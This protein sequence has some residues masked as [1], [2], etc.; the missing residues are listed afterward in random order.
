M[1]LEVWKCCCL[2]PEVGDHY[3]LQQLVASV[4]VT[5]LLQPYQHH[6]ESY[7][8][9]VLQHLHYGR[10]CE[11]RCH[12]EYDVHDEH[13]D[14]GVHDVCG[15]DVCGARGVGDGVLVHA[16]GVRVR[17]HVHVDEEED[18]EDD[19]EEDEEEEDDEEE[20]DEELGGEELDDE[21]SYGENEHAV[22]GEGAE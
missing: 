14:R 13:D 22:G 6:F 8:V 16:R 15:D 4:M 9:G 3:V 18:D 10:V 1:C 19:E 7:S 11:S 2:H 21:K 17:V 5:A 20:D 12:D